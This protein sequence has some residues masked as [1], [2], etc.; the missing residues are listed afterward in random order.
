MLSERQQQIIDESIKIIDEK[1]IQ[2]L[3]IKNLSKAIGISEPGIY[4]HFESKTEILLTILNNFKDMAL[5]L[6]G[7]MET[8]EASAIEKINF[9]FS[10]MLELFSETPSMVSVIFSEEIFKN[11]EILKNRIVE[12]LN[13]HAQTIENIISKGQTENTI[14]K[15]IDEKSLALMAMGSLRLLVKKWDINSHNFDLNTEGDKLIAVLSKV[16][17]K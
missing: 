10:K 4:R 8:Y 16:L 13:L 3:T 12:I 1:G 17:G 11:E 2:G 15:D 7:M 14:R 6:S 9:M 5:M